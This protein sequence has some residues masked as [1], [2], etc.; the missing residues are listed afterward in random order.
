MK[1][2]KPVPEN[3]IQYEQDK[4]DREQ[5]DNRRK[6][7]WVQGDVEESN[8]VPGTGVPPTH[9]KRLKSA[10]K[11]GCYGSDNSALNLYRFST[12]REIFKQAPYLEMDKDLYRIWRR[13]W[14]D[15]EWIIF[16]K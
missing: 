1:S 10:L 13:Y 11:K 14:R 16:L 3:P 9:A 2:S 4:F 5:L 8:P 15:Q 12:M 7:K 6:V